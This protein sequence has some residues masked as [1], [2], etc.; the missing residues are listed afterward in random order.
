MAKRKIE[1]FTS[2]CPVCEPAVEL[3]KKIA[4]SSCEVVI[5][6]LNAGCATIECREKAKKYGIAKVPTVVVDGKLLDCCKTGKISEK[7]LRDAGVGTR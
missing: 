5:Y 2:S 6:D 3:V 4:C 7:E 1:V